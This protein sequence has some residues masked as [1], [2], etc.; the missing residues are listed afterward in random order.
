VHL[1]E[2]IWVDEALEKYNK[3]IADPKYGDTLEV[4][5]MDM[6]FGG[7]ELDLELLEEYRQNFGDGKPSW[8][9]PRFVEKVAVT[10]GARRKL[11]DAR[12]RAEMALKEQGV[13]GI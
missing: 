1:I 13:A 7:E 5:A 8:T 3:I 6:G 10:E 9:M 11:D 4:R 12:R 2:P